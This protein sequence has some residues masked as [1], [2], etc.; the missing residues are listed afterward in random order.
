[1]GESAL[2]SHAK[3]KNISNLWHRHLFRGPFLASMSVELY[4]LNRALVPSL[5]NFSGFSPL[6]DGFMFSYWC[7]QNQKIFIYLSTAINICLVS[8]DFV[9]EIDVQ[10][11]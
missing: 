3:V 7:H 1:M 5:V 4:R 2:T 9:F 10:L 8:Y 6:I 11:G